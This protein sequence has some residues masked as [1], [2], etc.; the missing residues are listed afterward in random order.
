[1]LIRTHVGV[2]LDGFLAT[3][4]GFPAWEALPE[5]DPEKFG[6]A[7]VSEQCHA[8]VMGRTSFDQ[9]FEHWLADWPYRGKQV[10]V[11][12]SRPLP[13]RAPEMGVIASS[14]GPAGDER[15]LLRL[16]RHRALADGAIELVYA[17]NP[18]STRA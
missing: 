7:E 17:A 15:P 9:G 10:Y 16:E 14:R 6:V 11:L 13:E 12:T 8:I 18:R 2:S 5:F 4:D 3:P 1:M